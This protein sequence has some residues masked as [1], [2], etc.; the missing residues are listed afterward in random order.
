MS[1]WDRQARLIGAASRQALRYPLRSLLV[2]G[3]AAMGVAGAVTAVNYA[4]GGREQ[5]LRQIQRLGTNIVNVSAQQ[6]RSV[7][8]RTRTGA[9]VTTLR[10]ADL[11]AL[12]RE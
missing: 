5:V 10:Q 8:G 6:S 2:A 12:R 1:R 9:I 3:C 4:S 7:A 11:D